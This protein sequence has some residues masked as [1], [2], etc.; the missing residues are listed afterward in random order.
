MAEVF[1]KHQEM[2]WSRIYSSQVIQELSLQ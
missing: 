2:H 1:G